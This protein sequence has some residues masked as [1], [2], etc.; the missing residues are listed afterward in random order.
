[1]RW[2]GNEVLEVGPSLEKT[3]PKMGH[4]FYKLVLSWAKVQNF[5]NSE[6]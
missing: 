1:M 6:L 3:V 4:M 5:Q 2:Q